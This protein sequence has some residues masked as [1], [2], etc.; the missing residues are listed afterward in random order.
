MKSDVGER[1]GNRR[2]IGAVQALLELVDV[3]D[4]RSDG[5]AEPNRN[6]PL[7]VITPNGAVGENL[8]KRGQ[9]DL[10]RF[11]IGVV[12]GKPLRHH[13]AGIQMALDQFVVFLGIK[14]R[15]PLHPRVNRIGGDDVELFRVVKM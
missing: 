5:P 13:A 14:S 10:H 4:Y 1:G 2:I 11:R 6:H 12:N 7:Q 15:S 8:E 9:L 3:N